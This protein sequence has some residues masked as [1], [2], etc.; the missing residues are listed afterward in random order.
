MSVIEIRDLNVTFKS[1][2]GE[3]LAL[4]SINTTIRDGEF[5][6]IIGSS[7]CG[8]STLLGVLEGLIRPTKRRAVVFQQYT[9]FPW[10]TAKQNVIFA[11]K[12]IRRN[13]PKKELEEKE[14]IL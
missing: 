1:K 13:L 3:F 12:Q 10:M 9:L 6:C 14:V 11:V 8:K 2:K 4:D 5:V 7:G